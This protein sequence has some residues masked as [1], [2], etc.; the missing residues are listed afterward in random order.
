MLERKDLERELDNL[1]CE[2]REYVKSSGAKGVIV[3]NS[4]GKDCATVI[5]LLTR[6]LGKENVLTVTLPCQSLKQDFDDANLVA[7]TFGVK[8]INVELTQTLEVMI[9]AIENGLDKKLCDESIVNTKP[10]LRMTTLY[11]IAQTLGY[12]VIGTGNRCEIYVGYF[13]KHGD[14]ACDY[15]PLGEFTVEEVYQIAR[16][17]GVPEKIL[18]KAPSDGLGKLTDEQKL[19]FLYEEVEDCIKTGTTANEE[20]KQKIIRMH[21]RTEHKRKMPVIYKR[22]TA[23]S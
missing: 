3:G 21:E 9:K 12:L 6:A 19:G 11:A 2:L 1:E 14:G 23:V 5:G 10:R 20:A 13:T 18:Q 17:I 4:G 7:D 8:S 22:I 16:Y 15:N